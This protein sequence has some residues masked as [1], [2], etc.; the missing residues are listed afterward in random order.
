M[1]V[2]FFLTKPRRRRPG[3]CIFP[4]D[5]GVDPETAKAFR[6]GNFDYLAARYR[7]FSLV[8]PRFGLVWVA[9]ATS[10]ANCNIR[11]Y[12]IDVGMD[13]R[14]ELPKAM[15]PVWAQGDCG[16]ILTG[17]Q[18]AALHAC[19]KGLHLGMQVEEYR[20][21]LTNRQTSGYGPS[22][23]YANFD[24][25]FGFRDS[26]A[27]GLAVNGDRARDALRKYETVVSEAARLGMGLKW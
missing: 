20:I 18:V 16:G 2:D 11:L 17:R 3:G 26:L 4:E 15:F 22:D 6:M 13:A 5:A 24:D 23:T 25:S 7:L 21:A 1:S 27:T 10:A 9:F 19:M 8:N 14:K 12:R